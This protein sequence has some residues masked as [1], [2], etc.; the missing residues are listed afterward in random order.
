MQD[1]SFRIHVLDKNTLYSI[2][3]N[4]LLELNEDGISKL[5]IKYCYKLA[6]RDLIKLLRVSERH[7]ADPGEHWR[8]TYEY[9]FNLE[10]DYL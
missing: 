9:I 6:K 3:R 1:G 4:Q 10:I 7:V 2:D 5:I 8:K